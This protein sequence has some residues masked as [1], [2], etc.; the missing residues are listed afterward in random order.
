M[1]SIFSNKI[2]FIFLFILINLFLLDLYLPIMLIFH[3]PQ[4]KELE[5]L[6]ENF[7]FCYLGIVFINRLY[8]LPLFLNLY[9]KYTSHNDIKLFIYKLKH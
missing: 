4:N 8:L 3:I 5:T 6:L 7:S 2:I 1:Q 9:N